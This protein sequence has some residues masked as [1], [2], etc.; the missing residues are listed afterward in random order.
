[1]QIIEVYSED[2][3]IPGALVYAEIFYSTEEAGVQDK[4]SVD[5]DKPYLRP[6]IAIL[7]GEGIPEVPSQMFQRSRGYGLYTGL[8]T[9]VATLDAVKRELDEQY[10]SEVFVLKKDERILLNEDQDVAITLES[11]TQEEIKKLQN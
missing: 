5:K 11:L 9:S 10:I 4:E 3:P 7:T 8:Y 6:S 2:F 1:M